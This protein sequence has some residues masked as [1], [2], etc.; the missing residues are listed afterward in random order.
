[1]P[2]SPAAPAS[3]G[4]TGRK[5]R[6]SR[7]RAGPRRWLRGGGLS[8][9]PHATQPRTAAPGPQ[10]LSR[11]C[12]P[13]GGAAHPGVRSRP[14][15]AAPAGSPPA[16]L[17]PP[18]PRGARGGRGA[19]PPRCPAGPLPP[20]PAEGRLSPP[21]PRRGRE[22]TH[23]RRL[24]AA[25]S[26]AAA[27]PL[28]RAGDARPPRLAGDKLRAALG[29]TRLRRAGPVLPPPP[30]A[31][32]SGAAQVTAALRHSGSSPGRGAGR[33]GAPQPMGA[34]PGRAAAEPRAGVSP[35]LA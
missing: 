19:R 14:G 32:G 28:S 3:P 5:P 17:P 15:P 9:Q 23:R 7:A 29:G 12:C 24:R 35:P 18:R 1:M 31:S 6:S 16:P 30:P 4:E 25:L 22:V 26:S 10:P 8:P 13:C 34:G 20:Q 21:A 27:A 33:R 2:S 11:T